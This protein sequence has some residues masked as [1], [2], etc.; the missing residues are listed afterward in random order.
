MCANKHTLNS[1]SNITKYFGGD[2][3]VIDAM[4]WSKE[5]TLQER[6]RRNYY[7]HVI[8]R[9]WL[10][11]LVDDKRIEIVLNREGD[12]PIW[13]KGLYLLAD[14]NYLVEAH[15]IPQSLLKFKVA[16]CIYPKDVTAVS[17]EKIDEDK[18][19]YTCKSAGS[20]HSSPIDIKE[21]WTQLCLNKALE[22]VTPI[23]EAY[24]ILHLPFGNC[25]S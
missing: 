4:V 21:F 23:F 14:H 16:N 5:W 8:H 10:V 12:I 9:E 19:I 2:E 3:F 25:F 7:G 24:P 6:V 22:G 17:I 13:T 20:L 1:I 18:Y 15:V 11:G